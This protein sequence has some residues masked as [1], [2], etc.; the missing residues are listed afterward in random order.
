MQKIR[1][2]LRP[3]RKIKHV[4]YKYVSDRESLCMACMVH[5][6]WQNTGITHIIYF[7]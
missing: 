5:G 7:C 1:G 6:Q 2:Q 4:L 3:T